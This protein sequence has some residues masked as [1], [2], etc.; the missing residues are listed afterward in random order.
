MIEF[1]WH[2]KG[3][4]D[5]LGGFE[6]A[7]ITTNSPGSDYRCSRMSRV[8]GEEEGVKNSGSEPAGNHEAKCTA[9]PIWAKEAENCG[10]FPSFNTHFWP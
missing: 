10:T 2:F 7:N 8:M 4:K 6:G 9:M 3:F 1:N 5:I